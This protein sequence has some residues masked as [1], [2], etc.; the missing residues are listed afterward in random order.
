VDTEA[1]SISRDFERSCNKYGCTRASLVGCAI[2]WEYAQEQHSYVIWFGEEQEARLS[3]Q[4]TLCAQMSFLNA[5]E[6]TIHKNFPLSHI[7]N[8]MS[9]YYP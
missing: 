1:A 9:H 5:K 8:A 2:L 6:K 7:L 4:N 3:F